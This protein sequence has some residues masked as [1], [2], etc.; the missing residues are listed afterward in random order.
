[1]T[2]AIEFRPARSADEGHILALVASAGLPCSDISL[3]RQDFVVAVRGGR[4]V[5]CAGLEAFGDDGLFRSFAVDPSLRG[6]GLGT[7]LCG[8][9][10]ARASMRGLRDAYLLTTTAEGFFLRHGFE[11]FERAAVPAALAGSPEFRALCPATAVCMHRKV[12]GEAIH[13]PGDTLPLRPDAPG[14]SMWAVALEK[15]MLTY[16]EVE[17]RSRFERHTHA[18]EQITLVLEGELFF[19]VA[20]GRKVRV[21]AGEVIA[22]PANAPHAAWTEERPARAVDAWSPVR[23]SFLR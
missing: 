14:A 6:A 1:M 10:L 11:R 13:F 16:F 21:E 8:R 5:G 18:S 4:L 2:A 7:A 23:T 12:A 19:E 3:E 22:I 9:V 17:P 20:G 15:T